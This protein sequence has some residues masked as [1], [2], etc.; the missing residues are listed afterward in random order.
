MKIPNNLIC[1]ITA[2]RNDRPKFL[3]HCIW[4]MKRQTY[5]AGEHFILN[6]IA[7][8][9]VVDIVPRIRKG[10]ELAKNGGF[11]YCIIIENDDYYPDDYVEKVSIALENAQMVGIQTTTLYLLQQNFPRVSQHPGRSSLFCT[12]FKIS[13]L[14]NFSWPDTTLLYFDRELWKHNCNKGYLNL[15][16]PPIGIKHGV[17]FCPGNF[18]N[19]IQNGKPLRIP[20]NNSR[21]WLK[22]RVRK[23]SF[24]FYKQF[25]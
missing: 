23:E 15:Q 6:D 7:V 10:I 20:L 9:G 21:E 24:E 5:K 22:Q 4:Q 3:E 13:A 17:G 1:L 14:E 25:K 11:E 16:N 2:D 18:H 12:A 8:E 19:G